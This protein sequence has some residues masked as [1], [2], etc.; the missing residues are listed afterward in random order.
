MSHF[1]EL[2]L[3][4]EGRTDQWSWMMAKPGS[5]WQIGALLDVVYLAQCHQLQEWEGKQSEPYEYSVHEK[6]TSDQY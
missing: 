4:L 6:P 3:D 1:E 5:Q 2:D